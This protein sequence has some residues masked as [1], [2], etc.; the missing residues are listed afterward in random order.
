MIESGRG[1][2]NVTEQRTSS[3]FNI[4]P[5]NI[6]R[7]DEVSDPEQYYKYMFTKFEYRRDCVKC[8]GCYKL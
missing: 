7:C 1:N 3:L 4:Y 8:R 2:V 5:N 6:Q